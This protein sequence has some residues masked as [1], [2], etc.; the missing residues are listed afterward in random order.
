[1]TDCIFTTPSVAFTRY[2]NQTNTLSILRIVNKNINPLTQEVYTANWIITRD[3]T[4]KISG[5]SVKLSPTSSTNALTF[6][7]SVPAPNGKVVWVSGI[8]NRDTLN[9]TTV[10]LSGL[11]IIPSTYTA[12]A[13]INTNE[14]FFVSGMNNTWSDGILTVTISTTGTSGNLWADNISAPQ[15][16]AIDFGAMWYWQDGLPVQLVT[17]NTVSAWD[18]WNYL[19]SNATLS[20]SMW[21]TINSINSKNTWLTQEEHDRLMSL[22]NVWGGWMIDVTKKHEEIIEKYEKQLMKKL[23]E[24]IAKIPQSDFSPILQKIAAI[25]PTD[26]TPFIWILQWYADLIS[27]IRIKMD[28]YLSTDKTYFVN[29]IDKKNTVL[30]EKEYI[31]QEAKKEIESMQENIKSLM[32]RIEK[33]SIDKEEEFKIMEETYEEF[34]FTLES[35]IS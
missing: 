28:K 22:H 6:T 7:M 19:L 30:S 5:T 27:E 18:V 31:I 23:E 21:A 8:L 33:E 16:S 10:T 32:D 2:L 25:Q 26:I 15:A 12:S 17:A 35:K 13:A 14:T 20:R 24:I 1:M 9:T 4:G 3:E 11:G 34:L 29:E